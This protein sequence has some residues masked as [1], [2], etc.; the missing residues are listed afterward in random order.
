MNKKSEADKVPAVIKFDVDD[1]VR[2]SRV[3]GTF[4][5]GY[6]EK[7]TRKIYQINKVLQTTPATYLLREYDGS[8]V[9]GS[10]YNEELQKVKYPDTF[11]I[12]N[13]SK[14]RG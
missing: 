1:W 11:L 12:E 7:W 13:V 3:K 2:L 8:P 6:H 10:F 5:K 9:S 14:K 4:E